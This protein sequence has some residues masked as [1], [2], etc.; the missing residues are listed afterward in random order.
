HGSTSGTD[1]LLRSNI[2]PNQS[3]RAPQAHVD[4]E[5]L[6]TCW[7]PASVLLPRSLHGRQAGLPRNQQF[8]QVF[9]SICHRLHVHLLR[10]V[11]WD[12]PLIGESAER[13]G[14][15]DGGRNRSRSDL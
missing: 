12:T 2:W 7:P 5:G 6:S 15:G 9:V 4:R 10:A 14:V 11:P 1:T 8:H 3:R 13:S